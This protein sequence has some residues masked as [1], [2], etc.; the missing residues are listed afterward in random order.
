LNLNQFFVDISVDACE[1]EKMQM[2]RCIK[3]SIPE[4]QD[5]KESMDKKAK[6]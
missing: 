2:D 3:L 6:L 5:D 1:E 4:V